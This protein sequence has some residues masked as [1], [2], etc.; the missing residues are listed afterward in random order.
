MPEGG[1]YEKLPRPESVK[2]LIKF[3]SANSFVSDIEELDQQILKIIRV[4]KSNLIVYLTNIYIVS[5]ADVNEI[6]LENRSIDCIVTVSA[7][8][9]Y[10]SMAKNEAKE[11]NIGLFKFKEFLGAIYYDGQEF[12]DYEPKKHDDRTLSRRKI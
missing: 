7:W 4:G 10:T 8:N 3:V 6:L 2:A 12:I 5:E 9:K 1:K 11:K